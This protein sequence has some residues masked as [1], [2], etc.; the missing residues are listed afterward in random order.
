MSIAEIP[1]AGHSR[2]GF[3]KTGMTAYTINQRSTGNFLQ[4][5]MLK[6]IALF[7]IAFGTISMTSTY[8]VTGLIQAILV[9]AVV[10]TLNGAIRGKRV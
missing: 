10:I 2:I 1:K 3:N 8:S 5:S 7:L 9:V 6:T 4:T